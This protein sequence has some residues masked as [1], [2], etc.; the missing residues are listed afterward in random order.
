MTYMEQTVVSYRE[1]FPL[2]QV[3]EPEDEVYDSTE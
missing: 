3:C 1:A 2:E